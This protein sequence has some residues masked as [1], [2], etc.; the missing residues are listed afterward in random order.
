MFPIRDHNPSGGVP[1]VT[2]ALIAANVAV[3]LAYW[4]TLGQGPMLNEFFTAWGLVPESLLRGQGVLTP[5]SSMFLHGGW[6]HLIGNMWFLWIFGDNLEE[7]FGSRRFLAFYLLGGLAAAAFQVA[8]EP[9]SG[10]PMVGASGA[11]AGVM[12]GYL[13]LFPRARIDVL[14]IFV[15]F[16][17]IF[18][19]PAW[20]VLGVWIGL[21]FFNGAAT[22]TE[23]GGVAYW[24][25]VGGFAGGFVLTIPALLRR[26]GRGY[27][28]RT[29]GQPPH[30]E[31]VYPSRRTSIPRVPRR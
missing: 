15:I 1:F 8:A 7:E 30:P 28:R 6:G 20:I 29:Q 31:A 17:R 13:L 16:F 14:F 19:I 25:H 9:G 23:A 12:G 24:A 3:F 4:T 18:A 11:I 2:Y 22:P 26:G 10:I 21:Q 5:F 27:W